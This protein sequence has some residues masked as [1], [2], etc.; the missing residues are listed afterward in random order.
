MEFE[1]NP[2]VQVE[3]LDTDTIE[4]AKGK[5]TEVLFKVSLRILTICVLLVKVVVKAR[6][7]DLL[8]STQNYSFLKIRTL[9]VF[10]Q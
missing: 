6:G 9:D 5:I 2:P 10:I 4:Q 3:V 7:L 1:D 8:E